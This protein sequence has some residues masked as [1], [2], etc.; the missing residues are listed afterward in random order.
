MKNNNRLSFSF[1]L[2]LF[3][4]LAFVFNYYTAM[5]QTGPQKISY[6]DFLGIVRSGEVIEV[7][8]F[9][10]ESGL[11]EIEGTRTDRTKFSVSA[12]SDDD[13]LFKSLH[14]AGVKITAK[15]PK[16][17]FGKRDWPIPRIK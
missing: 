16:T 4:T 15:Q 13:A 9:A 12:P 3:I 6:S 1:W 8:Y 10:K 14:A 7:D 11:N 2:F 5:K 17:T